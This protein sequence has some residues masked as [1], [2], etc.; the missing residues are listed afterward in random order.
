MY[1]PSGNIEP[2]SFNFILMLRIARNNLILHHFELHLRC[3]ARFRIVHDDVLGVG[4]C[5]RIQMP[6]K[7]GNKPLVGVCFIESPFQGFAF[8]WF[9]R[10]NFHSLLLS[11]Q[12]S[13]LGSLSTICV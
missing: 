2:E 4:T 7:D 11:Q 10:D 3:A 5:F 12:A 6:A 9:Q 13:I 1:L 8:F